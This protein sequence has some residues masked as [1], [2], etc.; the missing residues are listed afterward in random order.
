M[1]KW[2]FSFDQLYSED[3]ENTPET[4]KRLVESLILSATALDT[5]SD[6]KGAA[7]PRDRLVLDRSDRRHNGAEHNQTEAALKQSEQ[8]FRLLFEATPKIAVQGYNQQRQ[9]IYWN[10]ASE[11]LYG[12]TKLE[13]IGRQLEDLIIP[14]EMRCGVIAA[15][16]NWLTK[17]EAIPA[18]ELSLMRKDGSRVAVY[19]SHMML[20]NSE[21]ESEL[22]CV[23]ID[24]SD[25]KQA[26]EALRES[27]SRYRL[28]A[29]NT[30][31]L[32]CL[33]NLQGHYLYVSP[34]C[35]P[36]LGYRYQEMLGQDPYRFFHPDDRDRIYQEA[37]LAA[38]R[39]KPVPITYRILHKS[40]H[41][42]WFET[43][44]KPILN[45]SGEIVQLQTTSRDVTERIQAQAQL[46]YDALH[47]ELTGLP[48]RYL[49]ME[50]L[51]LAINR[52]TRFE[53][54]HFA[55]LFLDLDRFKVINDSLGH[56]AGD[57]LLIAIA[58]KLQATLRSIDLAARLGGDEFVI[59]LEEITEIQEAVRATERIFATLQTPF[60]IEGRQVYT[61]FSI[62]IVL[63]TK[64]YR[65]ASHL[66]RDADIAMYRA[67]NMGKARYEIFDAEMHS[68]ALNRLHV[69]NDLRRA[70]EQQEFVLHYQPILA[71]ETG[72]LV[73]FEALIR[74][75]HPTQ[76][77]K[78]PGDFIA[79]A[80]ETGLITRLD[81]WA[82][83]TACN[84]LARWRTAFPEAT[85]IR[86]SVN[87][88][89]QDLRRSNLLEEVDRILAE[90]RLRGCYLTLEITESMLIEDVESTITLL[91]QLKERAIQ[92]SIDDF[93]TG[94]SSL[95]YLHR[96]PVDN[97]KVDRSFV[98][99]IQTGKQNHQIV[100]TIA[101][102]S[103]QLGLDAIAEGIE[104][105]QQLDRLKQLGY[106]FGQGYLFSK[107]LPQEAAEKL[108]ADHNSPHRLPDYS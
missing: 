28:L 59:L 89:V 47:D 58:Q 100:E 69:E 24:L 82:L 36:L 39:G 20:V 66:L 49:L 92:I 79:I 44:T 60:M 96:L 104:T 105:P 25:C 71:L 52:T 103:H 37:H 81:Y 10:H 11:Q 41:Y 3:W 55:V 68:Q 80:E 29:E 26:E 34:S 90:T 16:Q 65:Q 97:L 93:G 31:D 4:I 7:T 17:G 56:L 73:G 51:E 84:Q 63:N 18:G 54:Y 13:A 108:L 45:A 101:A 75:Q 40:G 64:D 72:S 99:Q 9:V 22:Y 95:N 94:Y 76:G 50:R 5:E 85:T 102:L 21:G 107:P 62:G 2:Q 98:N 1:A 67:K 87:L 12:Y 91:S 23:D 78:F 57:Q 106:K 19:S 42:V 70:I 14:P 61:T 15:V 88:S 32:V 38:I 53:N 8:R 35:E 77:L 46:R 74:W 27:E 43:L 6:P 83:E 33:H 86:M 48:N 30:N